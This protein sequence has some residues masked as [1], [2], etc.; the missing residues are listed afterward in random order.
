MD[1]PG[2]G[3]SRRDVA[4]A[5]LDDVG[6]E[7]VAEPMHC[8]DEAWLPR[9]VAEGGPELGDHDGEIGLVH[10]GGGPEPLLQ[11][12][13]GKC[14]RLRL[15]QQRQ[16]LVR[17]GRQVDGPRNSEQLPALEVDDELAKPGSHAFLE[18]S[19]MNPARLSRLAGPPR[20]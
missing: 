14:P 17:L 8:P 5:F 19:W 20:P 12:L 15:Y 13:F 11:L 16:E 10:E 3:E 1:P 6:R 18:V 4:A 9:I 7:R 2:A